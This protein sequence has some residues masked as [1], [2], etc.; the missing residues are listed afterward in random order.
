MH[1]SL[2]TLFELRKTTPTMPRRTTARLFVYEA[3]WG[4]CD[5]SGC[6]WPVFL[7]ELDLQPQ[8]TLQAGDMV[9][10]EGH[11]IPVP[12]S[13]EAY[14]LS[15][16][17]LCQH[18]VSQAAWENPILP[19][20]LLTLSAGTTN[21]RPNTHYYRTHTRERFEHLSKRAL[22][23]DRIRSFFVNR[24]FAAI[25]AP[26]LVPSGSLEAYLEPFTV[27]YQDHRHKRVN[28]QLPTSPE[29]ALKKILCEGVPR[30]FH[31]ARAYR[32]NGELSLW[33][34][35][36]FTLLEWYRVQGTLADIL[37]DTKNLVCT[38]AD[39]LNSAVSVPEHWPQ[40][41]VDA[42]FQAQLGLDLSQLQNTEAFF[43][44][45][46]PH[47]LSIVPTDTWDDI[48]CKLFLEKIE[49]FLKEQTACFVTHYPVQMA[50]LAAPEIPVSGPILYAQRA[51]AFLHGIEICNAYFELTD[52]RT[53][54]AR[55]Q[56][57]KQMKP[58]LQL[59]PLFDNAMAFG[60][61]PCA[62]NAL[63]VDRVLAILR[64][65]PV[66][67]LQALPFA[68]QFPKEMIALE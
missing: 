59:D 26:T 23:L 17:R 37:E 65:V 13:P 50:A 28:L 3:Q 20:P 45:A 8:A 53:L 39:F 34:E 64:G 61:P 12:T 22:A 33:H 35:P 30:V 47:S 7:E 29:L 6:L 57:A 66:A 18:I 14:N 2:Q 44:A 15:I 56:K 54:L 60:L 11:F 38:L 63:G 48:F 1:Y 41:R 25:E 31:I 51:E 4:L 67:A 62:G 55:S 16:T 10:F 42:L 9:V 52:A 36:E 27:T 58:G 19:S 5:S 24:G 49:P 46:K 40:F 21:G 43:E 68:S 32:N